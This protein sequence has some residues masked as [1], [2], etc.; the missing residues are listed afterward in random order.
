MSSKHTIYASFIGYI[1]QAIVNN[2]APLLFSILMVNYG[3]DIKMIAFAVSFN[4][5]TQL[6]VD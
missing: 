2:L 6:I 5:V 3:F 4:F 1:T